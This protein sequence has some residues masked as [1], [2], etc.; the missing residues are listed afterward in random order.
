MKEAGP[1]GSLVDFISKSRDLSERFHH[2]V[3]V[4]S[5]VNQYIEEDKVVQMLKEHVLCN[6]VQIDGQFYVQT[7]VKRWTGQTYTVG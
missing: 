2:S 1:P 7:K 4:D 3:L 5:V 6:I